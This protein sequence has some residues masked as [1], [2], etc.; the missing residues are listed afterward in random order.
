[1]KVF[2]EQLKVM[3]RL[4]Q[5]QA[6]Y[7][8]GNL[9]KWTYID[10]M[11][12][13]HSC[14]F[15]YSEFIKDSNISAIELKDDKVVMTFRD[16][17]IKFICSKNDKRLAPFDTINFGSYEIEELQM[18]INLIED[19]FNVFDIGGNFG[20]YAMHIAKLRP[21]SSVYSFEPIPS[22]FISLKE[23]V[24]LNSLNNIAI[25]NFG[26]S[27]K[28]GHF[29]FYF[30]PTLSVNA[31]LVNVSGKAEIE[32]TKCL[33]KTLDDFSNSFNKPIDFIK[34]DVEGAEFF[35]FK[36]G[37]DAI[38]KN[39]P[40]VFSE[41]LRKWTSKFNYHPNDIIQ[42]FTELGYGCYTLKNNSLQKFSKVDENT[43]E[44]NYFFLHEEKHENL[45]AKYSIL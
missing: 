4:K 39:K 34:C 43:L 31:S 30:D 23:N 19:G 17:G 40:I 29:D 35:V 21:L 16:S 18:Q 14:L 45:V 7:F 5:I 27:D 28:E 44:T 26:F 33:V 37:I 8:S 6:S 38:K 20:W 32:K 3:N 42:F 24:S 1:M 15:D 12:E 36:G 9:D 22:T 11:Y 25:Y 13:L 10:K 41:M 2:T